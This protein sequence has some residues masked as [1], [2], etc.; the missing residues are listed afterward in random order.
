M[1]LEGL[2]KNAAN[3]AP[4]TPLSFLLRAARVY[5]HRPAVAY[6]GI[7][8]TWSETLSRCGR[9]AAALRKS[10]V[11]KGDVVSA[12]AVNTPEIF[13]MHFAVP[14]AGAV[15]NAV[16]VRLDADTMRY[17]FEHGEAKV[18]FADRE[19]S[20]KVKEATAGMASPPLLVD[21]DDPAYDGEGDAAGEC[22]YESFL[23]RAGGEEL[24]M[25]PDDEWQPISLNYTSGTTGRPKGVV[26][27]HRGAHL[28]ATASAVGWG[29][30]MHGVLLYTVPMFHCNGWCYPWT[31]ALLAGSVVCL[32]RIDGGDIL[33]LVAEHDVDYMGGAPIVLNT[34]IDAAGGKKLPR[35][36]RLV[37]AAAPPPASTLQAAEAMGFEVMHVYGLTETYGHTTMCAWKGDLWD[38]LPPDERAGKMIRQGV[39]YPIALEDWR[40]FKDGA[41]VP[42]DGETVGEIVMRGNTVMSGYLKNPEATQKAFADGW[43][44]TGDLAVMHD[45]DYMQIKDRLKDIIISGGENISSI[46]VENAISAHPAVAAVAVVAKP[47]PKWGETPCA[48]VEIKAGQ[49]A[50]EKSLDEF[51]RENLPG[52]MR[53]RFWVLCELPKTATGKIK[54]Y[55]LRERAKSL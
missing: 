49:S 3:Y 35:P 5:P 13:E 14:M 21:I 24:C 25:M 50:D 31:Q 47:D 17:I 48:F 36:V 39:G 34:V 40:V 53:P 23:E 43:F 11:K 54:K 2:E 46:A 10:G 7:R 44:H 55:E 32:R 45:D 29:M 37:T 4:L 18:V 30:K 27:H 33:R 19:F 1:N 20:A 51:C 9:L 52:F 28:M 16:N 6:N 26:Y 22:D 8:R 42:H 12:V 38:S 41:E 15:L